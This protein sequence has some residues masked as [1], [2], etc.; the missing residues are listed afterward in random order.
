MADLAGPL[1]VQVIAEVMGIDPRH[2]DDIVTV[3]LGQRHFFGRP[4]A[5]DVARS[6][7]QR[8]A[9][10]HEWLAALDERRSDP[11]DDV[12]TRPPR[13]SKPA[14]SHEAVRGRV[15]I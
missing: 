1:P 12:L 7:D 4:P 5:H 15:S 10:W 8:L 9:A 6:F 3:T 13:W 14:A 11:R 2:L